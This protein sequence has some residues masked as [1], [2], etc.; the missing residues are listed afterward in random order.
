LGVNNLLTLNLTFCNESYNRATPMI[1]A[2]GL[3]R[4]PTLAYNTCIC[5][6]MLKLQVSVPTICKRNNKYLKN[7]VII[8]KFYV[9]EAPL[10]TYTVR[11]SC[12]T[13]HPV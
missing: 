8:S 1:L 12:V 6:P 3:A 9:F 11:Q 2:W 10:M 13:H 5:K 7:Y 4:A